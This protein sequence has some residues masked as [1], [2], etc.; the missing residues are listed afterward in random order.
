MTTLYS[1]GYHDT[2]HGNT[3][4]CT[5]DKIQQQQHTRR[6]DTKEGSILC[7]IFKEEGFNFWEQNS[8]KLTCLTIVWWLLFRSRL[9][10]PRACVVRCGAALKT[11]AHCAWTTRTSY[12]PVVLTIFESHSKNGFDSFSRIQKKGFRF[13]ESNSKSLE[14]CW[15]K[16]SVLCVVF[17]DLYSWEE[18][19]SLIFPSKKGSHSLSNIPKRWFNSLSHVQKRV[20]FFKFLKMVQFFESCSKKKFN[21]MSRFSQRFNSLSHIQ[22]SGSIIWVILNKKVQLFESNSKKCPTLWVKF[23]KIFNSLSQTQ[24]VP[25]FESYPKRVPTLWV[26]FKKKSSTLWVILRRGSKKEVHFYGSLKKEFNSLNHV[27]KKKE[28][29]SLSFFLI[30]WKKKLNSLSFFFQNKNKIYSL[31]QI[32]EKFKS[33]SYI[34]KKGSILWVIFR[35]R[36]NSL[37]QKKV[38]FF[39]SNKKRVQF[40]AAYSKKKSSILCVVLQE[41]GFNSLRHIQRKRVSILCVIFK[42][43]RVQFFASYCKKRGSIFWV[44]FEKVHF[45]ESYLTRSS[46]LWFFFEK[47]NSLNHVFTKK[48]KVRFFESYFLICIHEKSS[49]LWV[50]FSRKEKVPFFEYILKDGSILWVMFRKRFSS[51]IFWKKRFNSLTHIEKKKR[52]NSWSYQLKRFNSLSHVKKVQFF[53]FLIHWVKY[54]VKK[55]LWVIFEK[56]VQVFESWKRRIRFLSHVEKKG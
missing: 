27:C 9:E 6:F 10:P 44:I 42:E 41:K 49:I 7:V 29:H 26:K 37:R 2:Q 21:S 8:V 33:L 31:S 16:G 43:K 13:F 51:C 35:K 17:F 47:F 38:Q 56:S 5:S 55:N 53:E 23:K 36:L 3:R 46:I 22:K 19:N 28:I 12:G 4:N 15:K 1:L 14:S 11:S 20:Q 24:K 30:S 32:R 45:F 18:F 25:F 50:F 40:F 48:K 52:F 34:R 54:F 39:A